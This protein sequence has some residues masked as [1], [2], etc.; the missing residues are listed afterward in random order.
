MPGAKMFKLGQFSTDG[1]W[2]P[3]W[4]EMPDWWVVDIGHGASRGRTNRNRVDR[5]R[6]KRISVCAEV[7]LATTASRHGVTVARKANQAKRVSS[8]L[9]LDS[10]DQISGQAETPNEETAVPGSCSNLRI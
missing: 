5:S 8:P 4:L 2:R 6:P 3:P 9:M 1:P 10:G 7:P